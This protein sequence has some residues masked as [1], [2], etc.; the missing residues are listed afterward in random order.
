MDE[1][2]VLLSGAL[3]RVDI[4]S[5]SWESERAAL[6]AENN[7]LKHKLDTLTRMHKQLLDSIKH[8]PSPSP[9]AA[10]AAVVVQDDDPTQSPPP[11]LVQQQQL[12]ESQEYVFNKENQNIRKRPKSDVSGKKKTTPYY[13][14]VRKQ[15][16]RADLRGFECKECKEF[17]KVLG[18]E[19]GFCSHVSRHRGQFTPPE[20]PP[21]FWDIRTQRY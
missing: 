13:E 18:K 9:T 3:D 4:V 16:E 11:Y 2:R 12:S 6:V 7:A 10:A 20:T 21:G 5:S 19:K 8:T 1:L 15:S 17:Y 14:T